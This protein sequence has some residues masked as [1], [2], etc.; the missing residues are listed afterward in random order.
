MKEKGGRQGIDRHVGKRE[1]RERE[2]RMHE[3][4]RG[5]EIKDIEGVLEPRRGKKSR[6]SD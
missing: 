3:F 6:R 2:E 5:K 1:A 4:Q